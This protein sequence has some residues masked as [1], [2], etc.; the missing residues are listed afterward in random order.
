MIL[1]IKKRPFLS[2]WLFQT[3]ASG[4]VWTEKEKGDDQSL[5]WNVDNFIQVAK[6]MVI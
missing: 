5:N 2:T 6:E 3:L 4:S 1:L